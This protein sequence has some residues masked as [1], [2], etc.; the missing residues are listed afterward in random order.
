MA[1][2]V[3]GGL[4]LIAVWVAWWAPSILLLGGRLAGAAARFWVVMAWGNVLKATGRT[5]A[6]RRLYEAEAA[7]CERQRAMAGRRG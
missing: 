7:R 5:N 6:A 2:H 1:L 4:V 3:A